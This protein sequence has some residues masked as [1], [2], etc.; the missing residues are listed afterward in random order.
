MES[1]DD[2]VWRKRGIGLTE[3]AN[4]GMWRMVSQYEM[5]LRT[6]ALLAKGKQDMETV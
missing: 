1:G 3:K 4:A 5:I 2:S 6:A